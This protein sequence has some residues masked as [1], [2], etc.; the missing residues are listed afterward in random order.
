[1]LA[2]PKGMDHQA[3]RSSVRMVVLVSGQHNSISP[4]RQA[5]ELPL[6]YDSKA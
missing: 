2:S 5:D 6:P 4:R 1:M 3:S